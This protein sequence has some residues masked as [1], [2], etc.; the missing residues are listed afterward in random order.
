MPDRQQILDELHRLADIPGPLGDDEITIYQFAANE[1][2]GYE[3][4]RRTLERLMEEGK[5][6][7]RYVVENGRRAWA[8]RVR[9]GR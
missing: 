1:R 9:D 5:A 4:A 6:T 3:M 2:I 7:R 8:Y